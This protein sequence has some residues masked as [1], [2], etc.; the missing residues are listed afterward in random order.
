[1]ICCSTGLATA[2]TWQGPDAPYA[3][4]A[5][6]APTAAGWTYPRPVFLMQLLL[7]NSTVSCRTPVRHGWRAQYGQQTCLYTASTYAPTTSLSASWL[8]ANWIVVEL[9][10]NQLNEDCGYLL[11]TAYFHI[12]IRPKCIKSHHFRIKNKKKFLEGAHP[13]PVGSGEGRLVGRGTSHLGLKMVR[14]WKGQGQANWGMYAIGLNILGSGQSAVTKQYK[15]GTSTSWEGNRRSCVSDWLY[16]IS[17]VPQW[18][19]LGP[20]LFL[21]FINDRCS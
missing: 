9:S 10:I 7:T 3:T 8:S 21:I 5:A 1:M 2:Y 13:S 14:V 11:L 16:V 18:S 17:G 4:Q 12:K 6:G 15:F 19:I 20:V